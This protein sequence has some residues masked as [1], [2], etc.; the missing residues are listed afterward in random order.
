MKTIKSFKL[1][2][3]ALVVFSNVFSQSNV[4]KPF[5][6]IYGSWIVQKAGPLGPGLP[7]S[8][9]WKKYTTFGDTVV[10]AFTYKK[11]LVADNT[12]YPNYPNPVPF[13]PSSFSF[14]YRNDIQNKKVYYLDVTGGINKDTLW[15]DFNLNVGD[16]L[17]DTY[18]YFHYGQT[19]NNQRRIVSSI[20]SVLI[21]GTYYKR[22]NFN[23][24]PIGFETELIEG[25]GYKDRFTSTNYADC[26]FEPYY[27]YSTGFSTCN[28]TSVEDYL[29]NNQIKLFPNPTST[30]LKLNS[31]LKLVEYTIIN[32][33]GEVALKGSISDSQT[34]KISSLN[35]GLYIIKM[36]DKSGNSYE[37]KFIKQ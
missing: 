19:I 16:T 3:I 14:A 1:L 6:Q 24:T 30:D 7:T 27:I 22:F 23:C 11:V 12:G 15:Y 10:G 8:Y 4:Y 26:P 17:K 32:N 21:C 35:D 31:S 28:I 37:S 36:I 25:V 5:P 9:S 33:I 20:D 2:L 34:I 13:G 29:K 18:A